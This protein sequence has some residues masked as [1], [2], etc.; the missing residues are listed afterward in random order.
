MKIR[1]LLLIEL[2]FVSIVF[3][4]ADMSETKPTSQ[5]KTSFFKSGK[6]LPLPLLY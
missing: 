1:I 2:F 5:K 6:L 3:V 4:D